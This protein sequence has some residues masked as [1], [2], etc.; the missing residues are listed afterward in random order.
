MSEVAELK[1]IIAELEAEKKQLSYDYK[2]LAKKCSNL[3]KE[4]AA[5]KSRL[6]KRELNE[7]DTEQMLNEAKEG[8]SDGSDR[9]RN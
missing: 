7:H 4:N 8:D 2:N 1:E 3:L 5:L 9:I 6:N